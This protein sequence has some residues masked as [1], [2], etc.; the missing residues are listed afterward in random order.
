[1]A[2]P[3]I[4][5]HEQDGLVFEDF[6]KPGFAKRDG[7]K[8][9]IPAERADEVALERDDVRMLAHADPG[10]AIWKTSAHLRIAAKRVGKNRF[11]DAAHPVYAGTAGLAGHAHNA[12]LDVAMRLQDVDRQR[13]LQCFEPVFA[14]QEML[15]QGGNR[16]QFSK[17]QGRLRDLLEQP[18]EFRAV[19]LVIGK[20]PRIEQAKLRRKIFGFPDANDRR[21]CLADAVGKSPFAAY[22]FRFERLGTDNEQKPLSLG[23]SP[24][25]FDGERI[26]PARHR[27]AVKP[28]IE[29]GRRQVGVKPLDERL[30]VRACIGKEQLWRWY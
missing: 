9:S 14:E 18:L 30:I 13:I 19:T 17:P 22:I 27:H 16:D 10:D 2:M 4:I 28:G 5:E 15:R 8:N 26:T 1:M 21:D 25:D 23:N 6:M 7:I 29:A 24:L 11:A 3:D 20:I 12:A